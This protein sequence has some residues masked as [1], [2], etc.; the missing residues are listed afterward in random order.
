MS[1]YYHDRRNSYQAHSQYPPAQAQPY[2][3]NTEAEFNPYENRPPHQT[4]DEG[5]YGN[6]NAY[7]NG[8]GEYRDEPGP[9]VPSKELPNRGLY[10]GEDMPSRPMGPKYDTSSS[11][12]AWY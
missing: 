2:Q 3:D 11:Q 12:R 6:D 5:G 8:Y 9:V 4:Y 7:G 1:S 10:G